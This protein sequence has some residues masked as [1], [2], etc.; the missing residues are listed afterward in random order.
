MVSPGVRIGATS[1]TLSVCTLW[2]LATPSATLGQEGCGDEEFVD[3]FD[4]RWGVCFD[5]VFHDCT[6]AS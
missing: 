5:G 3:D 2:L 6:G 4:L 1:A